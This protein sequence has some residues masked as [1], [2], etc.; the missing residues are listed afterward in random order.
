MLNRCDFIGRLGKDVETV[1]ANSGTTVAKF[2]VACSEK[3][4][5]KETTEWVNCVAF[6]K[7]AEFAGNYL[8][9]GYLVYV[10]GKMQTQKWQDKEGRDR[11]TTQ[12]IVNTL[13]N[14]TPRSNDGAGEREYQT[15]SDDLPF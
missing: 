3:Y 13:Q 12:I 10:S 4:K 14:L 9:K 7:T 15:G 5:D 8:K 1:N 11:F 2:T 6:G